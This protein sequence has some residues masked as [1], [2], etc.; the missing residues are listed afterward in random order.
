[1]EKEQEIPS[2]IEHATICLTDPF[3][4]YLSQSVPCE[5]ADDDVDLQPTRKRKR[6]VL[7]KSSAHSVSNN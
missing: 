5:D 4:E 1:M 2:N 3:Q 7:P 6:R